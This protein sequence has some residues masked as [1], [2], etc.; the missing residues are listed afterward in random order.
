MI[1]GLIAAAYQSWDCLK[2]EV[3]GVANIYKHYEAQMAVFAELGNKRREVNGCQYGPHALL[4][5]VCGGTAGE[6]DAHRHRFW[7]GCWF[8]YQQ[9]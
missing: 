9:E 8:G 7:R 5:L 4:M 1:D 3:T 2:T 6:C